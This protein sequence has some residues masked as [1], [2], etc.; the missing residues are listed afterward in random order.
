MNAHKRLDSKGTDEW[1][2]TISVGASRIVYALLLF[3]TQ[4][5]ICCFI[6]F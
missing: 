2:A 4:N 5:S 1:D 3:N 6:K